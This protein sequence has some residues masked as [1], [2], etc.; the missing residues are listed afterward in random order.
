MHRYELA[1]LFAADGKPLVLVA[2][3]DERLDVVAAELHEAVHRRVHAAGLTVD[4]LVNNAGQG[5]WG[6]EVSKAHGQSPLADPA[7]VARDG[8]DALMS[9]RSS[10]VSGLATRVSAVIADLIPHTMNAKIARSIDEALEQPEGPMRD[11]SQ[12]EPSRRE[13]EALARRGER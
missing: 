12:H 9:G 8:H 7:T 13:H 10:I 5:V 3:L 11:E 4:V 6:A 1:R 2:R